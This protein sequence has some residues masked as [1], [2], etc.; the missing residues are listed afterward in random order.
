MKLSQLQR[1]AALAALLASA[2]TSPTAPDPF[3]EPPEGTHQSSLSA[4]IGSG[5]GGTSVTPQPN[6]DNIFVAMLRFRLRARPN[7][8]YFV[9]RA[10]EVG[11]ANSADGICQRAQGVSPWSA[12]DPPFGSSFVPFPRPSDGPLTTV[13]TDASGEGSLDFE[14]RASSLHTGDR[15]DVQMRL[16]DSESAP[17]SELRSACMTVVVR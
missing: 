10:P 12:S 17:T 2:C 6:P 14:F 1:L 11:R 4:V 16:V 7:T 15:F 8:T 3:A 5:T 9:Q 13:T